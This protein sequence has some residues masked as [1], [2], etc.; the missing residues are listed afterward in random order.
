MHAEMKTIRFYNLIYQLF[1]DFVD[2]I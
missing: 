1:Y 2:S